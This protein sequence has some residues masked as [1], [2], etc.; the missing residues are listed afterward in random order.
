MCRGR[1]DASKGELIKY[2]TSGPAQKSVEYFATSKS[3][4]PLQTQL[5]LLPLSTAGPCLGNHRQEELL[6]T[7][8]LNRLSL[9]VGHYIWWGSATTTSPT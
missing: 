3:G 6:Q 4:S 7:L 5:H 9:T 8:H 2:K 1:K